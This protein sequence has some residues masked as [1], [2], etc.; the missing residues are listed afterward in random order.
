MNA[1]GGVLSP[2]LNEKA[3]L[4]DLRFAYREHIRQLPNFTM[5]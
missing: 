1:K 4:Q 5:T 2:P 3:S